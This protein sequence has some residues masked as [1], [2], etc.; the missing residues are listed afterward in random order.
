VDYGRLTALLI[1]A[2]K[3]QHALIRKQQEQIRVQQAQIARLSS[4]IK[5]IQTSLSGNGRT[6]SEVHPVKA[7]MSVAKQ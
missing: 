7:T 4:Q 1:E 3:E 5:M 6:G 2:T